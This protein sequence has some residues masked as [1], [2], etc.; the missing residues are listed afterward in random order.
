MAEAGSSNAL[1]DVRLCVLHSQLSNVIGMSR[2]AP[3]RLTSTGFRM[4]APALAGLVVLTA[5]CT[6]DS[7]TETRASPAATTITTTA[8]PPTSAATSTTVAA[9]TTAAAPVTVATTTVPAEV[10]ADDIPIA[11]TPAGGWTDMPLPVLETCTEPLVNGAPDMRGTWEVVSVDVDGT[12]DPA[13]DAIGEV[14]RIEQCGDRVVI[15]AG[16]IVHDM[17]ADGTLDG[18]VHDVAAVDKT[19]AITVVASFENGV[20]VLRPVGVPVEVTRTI[21][22]DQLVW[23]YVGFV[24]RLDRVSDT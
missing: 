21:D 4:I 19:T 12:T 22:G 6:S 3:S 14:Q 20:H 10:A 13:H 18:A 7:A 5:A 16:G 24:A 17:R 2:I 11:Y 1:P 8:P 23:G 15:T 9:P